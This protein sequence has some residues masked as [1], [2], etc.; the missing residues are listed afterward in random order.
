MKAT[1]SCLCFHLWAP[2]SDPNLKASDGRST[3]SF[4]IS[5]ELKRCVFMSTTPRRCPRRKP[6]PV[7]KTPLKRGAEAS[8]RPSVRRHAPCL[9]AFF[10]QR[11]ETLPPTRGSLS[12]G[13]IKFPD[14]LFEPAVGERAVIRR[15]LSERSLPA[16][17]GLRSPPTTTTL[18]PLEITRSYLSCSLK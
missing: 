14:L 3:N 18:P 15:P 4:R 16:S 1:G 2:G 13:P 5:Q 11:W 8:V 10:N 7:V 12:D 6:P 17:W 9:A